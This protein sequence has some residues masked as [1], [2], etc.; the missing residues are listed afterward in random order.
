MPWEPWLVG[1][2]EREASIRVAA[3]DRDRSHQRSVDQIARYLD[4]DQR[5][6]AIFAV[7]DVMTVL[8]MRAAKMLD[9]RVPKDLSL[10]GFDDNDI[11]HSLLDVP[12]TM[13]AQDAHAIGKRGAQLLI[14]RIEGY[15]G[16]PRREH[17]PTH[18]KVR[19]STAPPAP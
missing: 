13:V 1:S 5:P 10:I 18:L 4:S 6:T 17:L 9:L 3:R 7:N 8:A 16:V 11:I 12:L 2:T 15:Q 14:E 19:G